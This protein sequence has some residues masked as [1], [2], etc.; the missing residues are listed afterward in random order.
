MRSPAIVFSAR[1]RVEIADLE[2]ASPRKHE[3]QVRSLFSTVSAGTE[4][5][6]LQGLLTADEAQF[7]CVPGYQRAGIVTEVGPEVQ[8]WRVGDRALAL[9]GIW[10][11]S[12]V[13]RALG[14]HIAVANVPTAFSYHIPDEVDDLD[15]SNAVVAQVGYNSAARADCKAR[16]WVLI[17]G[18]GLV[19]QCSAQ[20]ARAR[21]AR[22][23]L[24]GHRSERLKLALRYSADGI[25]NGLEEDVP[26]AVR[27]LVSADS[28]QVVFDAVQTP[29][30]QKQYADLVQRA[31]GRIVYNGFNPDD[32]WL[33]VGLLQRREL[34]AHFVMHWTRERIESTLALMA[35]G[36]MRSAPLITHVVPYTQAPDMY[37]L[38]RN[39]SAPFLGIALDWRGAS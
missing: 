23:I 1:D 26:G 11:T 22:V 21:G 35:S 31:S 38:I 32:R 37:Q 6:L 12:K 14:G 20:A 16:E 34:T 24:V 27:K 36:K 2:I 5:W 39:K 30:V 3:I 7:P 15:A 17:F 28:V 8:G 13:M 9:T 18:D 25:I 29:A 33:N 19:G 10:S 4:S